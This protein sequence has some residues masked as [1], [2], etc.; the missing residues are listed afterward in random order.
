MLCIVVN[1]RQNCK[2]IAIGMERCVPSS[3]CSIVGHVGPM[4]EVITGV[5]SLIQLQL[6]QWKWTKSPFLLHE[7]GVCVCSLGL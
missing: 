5:K 6:F 1:K 3:W 2:F 4:G 7:C